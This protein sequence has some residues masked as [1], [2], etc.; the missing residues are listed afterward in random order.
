MVDD[1][2]ASNDTITAHPAPRGA[3]AMALE[4]V[5]KGYFVSPVIIRRDPKTGKKVGD[6]LGIRWHDQS[7]DDPAQVRDWFAQYGDQL[8]YLVDTG[9]SGVFAVDLDVP[10]SGPTGESV[11]NRHHLPLGGMV[12]RTPGGGYHH[13]FRA[14][15]GTSL[16]V[17]KRIHGHPIDVRADGGHVYAPGAVVLG[18]TGE[19]ELRR[20]ELAS[21]LVPAADLTPLPDVVATFLKAK[22]G[23][24][25][26]APE[27]QGEIRTRSAVLDILRGQLDRVGSHERRT[28]SGFRGVLL[29]AGMP[30]GRAVA[31]GMT[32]EAGATRRLETAAA[33]V[34]GAV[35]ADDRRWIRHGIEDGIAD[36]WTVV[37]D[38]YDTEVPKTIPSKI[39]SQS[40]V[41]ASD[42]P[43]SDGPAPFNLSNGDG[44]TVNELGETVGDDDP[45]PERDALAEL[46]DDVDSWSPVDLG[47]YLDGDVI[48]PTPTVGVVREDGARFLYAGMEHAVIGAME[49]GK[50]WFALACCAAELKAGHRVLYVHFE[51][52]TPRS[53]IERLRLFNVPVEVIRSL[54]VFVGPERR[55]SPA[56]VDRIMAGGAPSLVV[57]DGQNEAMAL[58]GQEIMAPEGAAEYRRRLVKPW[59]RAGAAVVSLDHVVKDREEAGSGLQLGSVGKGN[60]LD[61]ALILLENVEPF[62]RGR[63]GASMVSVTK[64]RPAALRALGQ[65][66][67]PRNPRKFFVGVMHVQ[68]APDTVGGWSFRFAAPGQPDAGEDP[69]FAAMR[70][71]RAAEKGAAE[72]R[73]EVLD[74]VRKANLEE[75]LE[76]STRQ[77]RAKIPKAKQAVADALAELVMDGLLVESAGGRGAKTYSISR[78]A[79]DLTGPEASNS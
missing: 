39:D 30:F 15:A 29:G 20:Y 46:D 7:T 43:R 68:A 22:G 21:D 19:P 74:V 10:A 26:R 45:A 64:D 16:T 57:L 8:S 4:L 18:A 38:D 32:T 37:P 40:I 34:W 73:Q 5:A 63:D 49:A 6:Y 62:G 50:S 70:A 47:P 9:R 71:D 67:D 41:T 61:G 65:Q 2:N 79:L 11:W 76:P 51:E 23:G 27:A 25:R 54:F 31:A 33:K 48:A 53:T 1:D 72:L 56:D 42:S 24:K 55:I 3:L 60:G 66:R 44:E 13:Y 59:T 36:P 69:E 58:H 52:A 75:R 28:E 78:R 35:D 17:H 14:P 12:V 77:V